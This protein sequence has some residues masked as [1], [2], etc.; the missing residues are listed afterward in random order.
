MLQLL[1]ELADF[2]Q[3]TPSFTVLPPAS[4]VAGDGVRLF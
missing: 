1:L 4:T 2:V 3:A